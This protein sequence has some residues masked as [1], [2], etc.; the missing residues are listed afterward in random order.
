MA[1]IIRRP[2]RIEKVDCWRNFKLK[3]NIV[4][5]P[6]YSFP[7]DQFGNVEDPDNENY[8]KCILGELEVIDMGI[9]RI[10][11]SYTVPALLRCDCGTEFELYDP[12]TSECPNCEALFNGAGQRLRDPKY[13]GEE[14]GESLADI[15][16]G[17]WEDW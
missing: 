17:G 6:G 16:N 11:S 1:T 5:S 14:T 7:C 12:F 8:Q 3:G 4:G 9:E 13:W 2:Q 10:P 15:L